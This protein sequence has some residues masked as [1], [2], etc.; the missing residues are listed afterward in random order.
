MT[1]FNLNKNSLTP[2]AQDG[3]LGAATIKALQVALGFTGADVDGVIGAATALRLQYF[4]NTGGLG[5]TPPAPA[6][7]GASSGVTSS[8]ALNEKTG[9]SY[10]RY[11]AG[12]SVASWIAAACKARGITD[13]AAVQRWTVGYQTATGRESSGDANACNTNDS[14][15]VT[16]SGYSR[17]ADYGTGYGSPSGNLNGQLVNY[18]CSRGVAQCIPQTFAAYHCPNTSNMIYDP[19]ANIAA[20]MGYVMSQYGVSSDGSNLA[21]RVQQFDPNRPARGY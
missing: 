9:V 21:S 1:I 12:G 4:L 8:A 11:T 15:D 18:Q 17:V 2:V 10:A 20:S 16:P 5:T 13:S 14:N 19:V 7:G 3:V 6:S